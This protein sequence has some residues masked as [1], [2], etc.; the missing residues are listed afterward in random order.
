MEQ[1]DIRQGQQ[2]DHAEGK[3]EGQR[4]RQRVDIT[5]S[6]EF[7]LLCAVKVN[8]GYEI[9]EKLWPDRSNSHGFVVGRHLSLLYN[10]MTAFSCVFYA[11]CDFSTT[12]RWIQTVKKNKLYHSIGCKDNLASLLGYCNY[13]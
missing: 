13:V 8:I 9:D 3:C 1:T 2:A 7:T 6:G 5:A 4:K 12:T 11:K 10:V